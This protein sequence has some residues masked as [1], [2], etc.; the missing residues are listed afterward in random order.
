[1]RLFSSHPVSRIDLTNIRQNILTQLLM[2]QSPVMPVDDNSLVSV[3]IL[4]AD[5]RVRMSRPGLDVLREP[6]NLIKLMRRSPT[7]NIII[8]QY[9]STER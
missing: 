6:V 4:N 3:I 8:I 9:G 5:T 1:M 7:L 2:R